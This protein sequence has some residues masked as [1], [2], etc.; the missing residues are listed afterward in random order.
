MHLYMQYVLIKKHVHIICVDFV[1]SEFHQMLLSSKE[2]KENCGCHISSNPLV[3]K[4]LELGYV[5]FHESELFFV[6][7]TT[8]L[9]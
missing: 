5:C 4:A 8:T 9:I 3:L 7:R 2:N 1:T 6:E